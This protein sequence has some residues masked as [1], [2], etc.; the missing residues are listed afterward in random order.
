MHDIAWGEV[1]TRSFVGAFRELA[2]QLFKDDAHAEVADALGAQVGGSKP[3][4]YL[5]EQVGAGQ[6]Q[7]EV[8]EVEVLEDLACVLAEGLHVAH[9]ICRG[10]G[11]GESAESQRRCV[12]EL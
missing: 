4:H 2:D 7:N 1:L 5:I 12:E 8:L 9:Q 3:L 6:L 10:L 11:I